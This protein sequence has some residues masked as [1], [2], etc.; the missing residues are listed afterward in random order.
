VE[1]IAETVEAA[2]ETV[3]ETAT[4][5]VLEPAMESVAEPVTEPIAETI[6]PAIAL[7][8]E[9]IS[10]PVAEPIAGTVAGTIVETLDGT[11]KQAFLDA[12]MQ[13][14]GKTLDTAEPWDKYMALSSV[15]RDRLLALR[16]PETD[17]A[18]LGDR[19]VIELSA[20]YLPGPHLA[21]NLLAMGLTPEAQ[22][23]LAGLGI[24]LEDLIA[25]EEE[26]GLGRGGLGRLMICYLDSLAMATIPAIGYGIRYEFGIFDQDFSDGWQVEVVDDWLKNGNPWG[27]ERPEAAVNVLFGGRSEAYM[28]ADGRYRIRW[29]PDKAVRAIPYDTLIPGYRSGAASLLRLWKAET[30]ENLSK[31]LYPSDMEEYGKEVR[32][33]QQFFFVSASLQDA[34]RRHLEAGCACARGGRT[35]HAPASPGAP[36]QSHRANALQLQRCLCLLGTDG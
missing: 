9:P 14:R 36:Q 25:L 35:A 18:T 29:V 24:P 6:A 11:L 13:V 3:A 30:D 34:I 12:L 27:I 33:R 5:T 26:P 19:L 23:S 31:V 8:T 1:P 22:T 10:E 20:E 4:E 21:N 7:P 15:V 32:L 16:T 2:V 17:W 28:D